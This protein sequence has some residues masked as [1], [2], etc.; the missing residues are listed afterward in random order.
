VRA[1]R[2]DDAETP[3]LARD[4]VRG[5]AQVRSAD[6]PIWGGAAAAGP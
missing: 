6:L 4:L 2:S 1:P 5:F 3:T